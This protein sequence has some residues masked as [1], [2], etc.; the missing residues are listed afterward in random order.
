MRHMR[1]Y[2]RT[3]TEAEQ[4]EPTPRVYERW[5]CMIDEARIT[6]A[7]VVQSHAHA[8]RSLKP[9]KEKGSARVRLEV[10]DSPTMR[11]CR[12]KARPA[13]CH[14]LRRRDVHRQTPTADRPAAE[15][16][17]GKEAKTAG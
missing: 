1:E 2:I 16:T 6:I 11:R 5:T 14:P 9:A 12:S 15:A 7:I 3:R 13:T 17:G 10:K 4:P 8:P